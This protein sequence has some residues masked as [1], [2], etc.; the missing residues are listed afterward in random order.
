MK[1]EILKIIQSAINGADDN[2]YR[3]KLQFKH[4][5]DDKMLDNYGQSG[6]TCQSILDGYQKRL[7]ELNECYK[8][9]NS[10]Q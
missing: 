9:V 10:K 4:Y 8:W 1:A 5:S 7:D 3:A 6:E 2:L